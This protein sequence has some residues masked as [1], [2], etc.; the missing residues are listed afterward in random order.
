MPL[1][2]SPVLA[3]LA[4]LFI[5]FLPSAAVAADVST[6]T[7]ETPAGQAVVAEAPIATEGAA[8]A[9]I[10]AATAAP[11]AAQTGGLLATGDNGAGELGL[12]KFGN[13]TNFWQ[14]GSDLDWTDVAT[15]ANFA[16]GIQA[17]RTLW[18]WG[19]NGS[20]Q[21][22]QGDLAQRSAPTKVG[23]AATWESISAGQYHACGIQTSGALFCWGSGALGQLGTGNVLPQRAPVQVAGGNWKGVSLGVDSTCAVKTDGTLWCWGY[24]GS[25]QLGNGAVASLNLP[26]QVGTAKTWASVSSGGYHACATQ[27]NGTLWCWGDNNLGEAGVGTSTMLKAPAKVGADADWASVTGAYNSTCGLKTNGTLW[28]W[29]Y[30]GSGQLGVGD[31][32]GR[33]VPARVGSAAGWV[34]VNTT[35]Y[36]TCAKRADTTLWCW[37]YNAHGQ[38]GLGDNSQRSAP[39]QVTTPITVSVI[40]GGPASD[41][42][43]VI[44]Q[45]TAPVNACP[46]T[47]VSQ[48]FARLGDLADYSIA[49]GGDFEGSLEGW[50][51]KNAKVVPGNETLGYLGGSQSLALGGFG[52][53]GTT[54]AVSP[55]FCLNAAHPHFRYLAKTN[56]T[57]T[58]IVYTALRFRPKN[59]PGYVIEL[60][61]KADIGA[62]GDWRVSDPTPLATLLASSLLKK[63]G[64]VQ[65]VFRTSATTNTYGGIQI[66]NVLVDPYRRG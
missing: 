30:N 62:K 12:G 22:G 16:C 56:S 46:A 50:A 59:N 35:K 58:G 60:G 8:D 10:Q 18:C 65:L 13:E 25:G 38:L 51:L 39:V 1:R 21:L 42:T 4:S 7:V 15:G 14:A 37:G 49:P 36:A 48:V 40:G 2:K 44:S 9:T 23:V 43:L 20:G 28:C 31:T 47:P 45:D 24:G 57:T 19:G 6:I 66:D 64:T 11:V 54:E 63:G 41:H 55:E 3:L 53:A 32:T 29:G 52:S 17:D 34:S 33:K 61:S 5:V 26:K 27:T